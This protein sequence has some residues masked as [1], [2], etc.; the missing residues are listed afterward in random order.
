MKVCSEQIL[1]QLQ[2][3]N[4]GT[5]TTHLHILFTAHVHANNMCVTQ[6][7]LICPAELWKRSNHDAIRSCAFV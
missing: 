1:S 7:L 5:Q 3:Y 2:S 4:P 6:I